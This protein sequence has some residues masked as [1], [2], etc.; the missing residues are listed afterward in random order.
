MPNNIYPEQTCNCPSDNYR[1][2]NRYSDF[3][4]TKNRNTGH[5]SWRCKRTKEF[6]SPATSNIKNQPH[7]TKLPVLPT[8]NIFEL[9]DSDNE[10]IDDDESPVSTTQSSQ[11]IQNAIKSLTVPWGNL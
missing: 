1:M 2:D 4:P 6:S 8:G 7:H 9:L 3:I 5:Q 10:E 11:S